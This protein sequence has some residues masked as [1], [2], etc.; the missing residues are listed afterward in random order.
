MKK[1]FLIPV[2]FATL[3]LASCLKDEGFDNHEYGINDPD[4]STEAVGFPWAYNPD[5]RIN[6][7]VSV[8]TP[9]VVE[10]PTVVLASGDA[11]KSDLHVNLTLNPALVTAYNADPDNTPLATFPSGGYTIP[12]LKVTIPA[13]GRIG[14][15][16]INIPTTVGLDL[17][18]IYGLGFTISSVDESG[19]AI[20]ENLKNIVIGVNVK[21]QYDA[22]YTVT[23]YFFHPSSGSSRPIDDEKHLGTVSPTGCRAPHSDLYP[24]NYYFDFDVSGTNTLINYVSRGAAPA[25]PAAGFYTAD[26]PGGI[27]YPTSAQPG[28]SP[29]LQTTYNNTYN[30]ATKTFFM[31]YGYGVGSSSQ[32]GWTRNIYEKWVRE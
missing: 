3:N 30:P 28:T 10:A 18:K 9:Q 7:V 31:H 5:I 16:K 20:A 25:A 14:V 23:G 19:M 32:N 15:L 1:I 17:T 8:S 12:S 6:S 4:N 26:N 24:S 21:N 13:G 2:L 29:W 11:A 27:A 22:E